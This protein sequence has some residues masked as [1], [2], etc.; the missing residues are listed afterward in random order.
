MCF[1]VKIEIM[2][3]RRWKQIK[4]FSEQKQIRRMRTITLTTNEL[5]YINFKSIILYYHFILLICLF[6][7]DDVVVVGGGGGVGVD[8]D[9]EVLTFRIFG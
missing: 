3:F 6:V 1:G 5:K 9:V 2:P 4:P 8:S 7:D